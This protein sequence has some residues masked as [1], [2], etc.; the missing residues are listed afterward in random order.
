MVRI[1]LLSGLFIVFG[2]FSWAAG[3]FE[4]CLSTARKTT[5]RLDRMEAIGSCFEKHKDLISEESC[6]AEIKKTQIHD[7]SIELSEK[8]NAICFYDVSRFKTVESCIA[9]T[10]VFQIAAN[11]DEGVFECY[12]QFQSKVSRNQCL[13]ISKALKYPAKKQYLETHCLNN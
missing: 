8:L 5:H 7:K 10:S 13:Q 4:H 9:K 11:H 2:Q 6:F 1:W 3:Q 12:R